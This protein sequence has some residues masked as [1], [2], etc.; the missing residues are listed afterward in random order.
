MVLTLKLAGNCIEKALLYRKN[1]CKTRTTNKNPAFHTIKLS[2]SI[3]F[4]KDGS[5]L[6]QE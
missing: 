1:T 5:N 6:K 4:V 3:F 2:R